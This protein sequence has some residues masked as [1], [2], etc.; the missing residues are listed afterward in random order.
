MTIWSL[1]LNSFRYYAKSHIGTILG[2]TVGTM[3]LVGALLVG[4]SVK[5]S[6]RNMAE[7]RLGKVELTL[8]SDDRLFRS[9]LA[10][11]IQAELSANTTAMLQLS[12]IHI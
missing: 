1:V 11:Q 5:G 6:L 8:S 9:K 10:N 12:L 2:V 4:E 3:V 7:A